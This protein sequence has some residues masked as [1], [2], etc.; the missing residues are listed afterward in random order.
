MK[1]LR[2]GYASK[3]VILGLLVLACGALKMPIQ[4]Q[5]LYAKLPSGTS[6]GAIIR[7]HL[8]F[9]ETLIDSIPQQASQELSLL[10][11]LL[12]QTN[13]GLYWGKYHELNGKIHFK[14]SDAEK[15]IKSYFDAAEAFRKS[16]DYT[17]QSKVYLAIGEIFHLQW[18]HQK[19]TGYFLAGLNILRKYPEKGDSVQIQ[20][21]EQLG[22][23]NL[24]TN[25][26]R[27]SMNY[28]KQAQVLA[29]K[30][31]AQL[32]LCR[33]LQLMGQTYTMQRQF[34]LANQVLKQ[35]Q[36][37]AAK[38]YFPVFEMAILDKLFHVNLALENRQQA[39][40]FAF[41]K[42]II[43]QHLHDTI[44]I[45]HSNYLLAEV[46]LAE[47][48]LDSALT[49]NQIALNGTQ[50][51]SRDSTERDIWVQQGAILAKLNQ[52]YPAVTALEKAQLIED[53]IASNAQR[54]KAER[55]RQDMAIRRAEKQVQQHFDAQFRQ[56]RKIRH[57]MFLILFLSALISTYYSFKIR[58][59]QKANAL[60]KVQNTQLEYQKNQLGQLS[61]VKDQLFAVISHDLRSPL[62]AIQAVLD[63]LNEPGITDSER[64]YWLVRLHLQT[65]KTSVLLENLLYWAKIQM[66]NYRP[67]KEVIKLHSL[68]EDLSQSLQF[69]F[70][71]KEVQI[72][73]EIAPDFTLFS[74]PGMIRMALRNIIANAVKFSHT[75]QNVEVNAWQEKNS[76]IIQ[77]KDYGIGM[78]GEQL[79]KALN[80]QLS[81]FG[82]SGEVG[83]GMGL[84]LVKQFIENQGGN[85]A[86][87]ASV[88]QGCVFKIT[89]PSQTAQTIF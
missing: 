27:S 55:A 36:V 89:L 58:I 75:G 17:A 20:I 65:A 28:L 80:G 47:N 6:N 39:K 43:A 67:I 69:I 33:I 5:T 34:E 87:Q 68:V 71:E 40:F 15:A 56:E 72:K 13:Y 46:Y 48:R 79:N 81:R 21:L 26:Y 45:N 25:D 3:C 7:A 38:Q 53:R 11:P 51:R 82:T 2:L 9:V 54:L 8:T 19:A 12:K 4:A 18:A 66:N 70:A 86:G 78:T 31:K 41:K 85:L 22:R 23:C 57:G 74:D 37:I 52:T 59:R 30:S 83:S 29:K 16:R 60:L 10:L 84:S 64:K 73:N 62:W 88:N 50:G 42:R 1:E 24:E 14:M 61:L 77:V 63:T 49:Y 32:T 35:A 44:S 76:W